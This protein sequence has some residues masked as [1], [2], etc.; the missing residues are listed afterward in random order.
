MAKITFTDK[1]EREAAPTSPEN[2]LLGTDLNE[3][4]TSVNYLYDNA[5]GDVTEAELAAAIAAIPTS[6]LDLT[7]TDNI[8][9]AGVG[10]VLK[11][12][13]AGKWE[14]KDDSTGEGLGEDN[15]Q[16]DWEVTDTESDAYIKNKPTITEVT[17]DLTNPLKT[18]YDAA[19]THSQA[20]H[21]P[22][23]AEVNVQA[24]WDEADTGSDA[25]IDNKP[26]LNVSG[27]NSHIAADH[28]PS[29]AEANVQS[30]WDASSGDA[31]ILNKPTISN[32]FTNA[33][34]TKL[35]G[36]DTG[37][38][39]DQTGPEIVASISAELGSS[40]WQSGGSGTMVWPV[41]SGTRPEKRQDIM[42]D[43]YNARAL[44]IAYNE[45][46]FELTEQKLAE[47]QRLV[48]RAHVPCFI[49]AKGEGEIFMTTGELNGFVT[50]TLYVDDI[51]MERM[52]FALNGV[53]TSD[54][55]EVPDIV[56]YNISHTTADTETLE[57]IGALPGAD[58]IWKLNGAVID[59]GETPSSSY[60]FEE[61]TEGVYV[62]EV[63]IT[64]TLPGF[65]QTKT[66]IIKVED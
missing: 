20:T 16:V 51:M 18:N 9:G 40:L 64:A 27:W 1:T 10:Q 48:D 37:A 12:T 31:L 61:S 65:P 42:Q 28:A 32:D 13:V 21:A 24:D 46:T 5:D 25:Y 49:F 4:K 36:I 11:Y 8:A 6:L 38:T 41:V 33:Y 30:D 53:D 57:A 52:A 43:L 15:V 45:K 17:N 29:T 55:G 44:G 59:T 22:S 2:W 63:N 58:F 35:D 14:P 19:Y 26:T 56:F 60:L 62:V 50:T 7:D 47:Y 66:W 39:D 23:G 3:I 34:K 54:I